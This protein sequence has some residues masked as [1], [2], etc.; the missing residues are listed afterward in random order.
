MSPQQSAAKAV[1]DVTRGML[2]AMIDIA[3]SPERVFRAV[4]SDELVRWWGSADTYR[5]TSWTG[6]VRVGGAWRA[7]YMP[8]DG[9]PFSTQGEFVELEPSRLLVQTWRY[10]G[11]DWDP[12]GSVTTIAWRFEPTVAGTRVVVRH[13]GFGDAHASCENHAIGWERVLGWLSDNFE[14]TA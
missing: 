10:V 7:D 12:S 8:G 2:L 6:D 5:T 11:V 4:T 3:A 14:E 13:E 9:K 1:A